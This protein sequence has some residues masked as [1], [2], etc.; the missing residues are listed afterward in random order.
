MRLLVFVGLLFAAA[1]AWPSPVERPALRAVQFVAPSKE[2]KIDINAAD[3]AALS[4]HLKGVGD[5][6]AAAIVAYRD[7]H[8]PF[9]SLRDL[10][11]VKGVGPV[12]LRKNRHLIYVGD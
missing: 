9:R 5:K 1:V 4:R 7:E 3:A 12:L 8:G 6:K 11:Q 2:G 10:E